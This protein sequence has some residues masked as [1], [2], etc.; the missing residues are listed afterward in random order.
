MDLT[1]SIVPRSDQLNAEDFLTGPRTVTITEVS[2]GNAEQPVNVHVA[3]FP[4]RPFKPS[5]SMRRVMVA[6]WGKESSAYVGK[7]M[8]LYRDPTVRFGGQDVGGI[9]VSHMSHIDKRMTLALTVTRG[10]RAPYIVDPLPDAPAERPRAT[11][12]HLRALVTAFRNAGI[13]ER[14][15]MLAFA[16]KVVD[17]PI[18][19][20]TDL[21]SD[22]AAG[23]AAALSATSAAADVT[24]AEVDPADDPEP[25]PEGDVSWPTV[26]QPADA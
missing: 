4:D 5:K 20:A 16:A 25:D 10:K 13:T 21:T 24:A 18:G 22:E 9:R 3:E 19:S 15:E 14:E 2:S 6:A 1:E 11:E 17:R 23:V 26:A 7:R 12:Q 8:T